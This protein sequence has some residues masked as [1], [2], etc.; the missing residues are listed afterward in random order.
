MNGQGV[1]PYFA[2]RGFTP[3]TVAACGWSI[4]RLG[5]RAR[6]YGLP[7]EA[8]GCQ[9]WLIPYGT[10]ER[11]RLI[12]ADDIETY[13][14]GRYRQPSGQP[15]K[16]YD[17]AGWLKRGPQKVALAIEGEANVATMLQLFPNLP[18]VGLCGKRALKPEAAELFAGTQ[19]LCLW[20]DWHDKDPRGSALD[21][22][23]RRLLAV[24]VEGV[25]P[26]P[27]P[28]GPEDA[29]DYLVTLGQE[30]ARQRLSSLLHAALDAG[31][32][33]PPPEEKPTRPDARDR[34]R[35]ALF[36]TSD[37]L[38]DS[39][40]EIPADE[41]VPELFPNVS[42]GRSRKLLCPFHDE[43]TPSCHVHEYRLYCH[44]CG[45]GGDVFEVAGLLWNLD[46]STTE[47]FKEL[48]ALLAPLFGL[49]E[50]S[51]RAVTA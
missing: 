11:V 15:L 40:K 18:T 35:R 34:R 5:S 42:I 21:F 50:P 29:N 47:G 49:A 27:D 46:P 3:Q 8:A 32:H 23:A 38:R 43:R 24:G 28:G 19:R 22:N 10:F 4:E 12:D 41:W 37:G 44:G 51:C 45:A 33:V 20:L 9:V 1:H 6:R 2:R 36:T 39:L 31:P 13:K 48:L 16:L 30:D 25:F 7:P 17:P 14:G 26:V